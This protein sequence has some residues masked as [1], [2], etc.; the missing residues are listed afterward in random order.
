MS[1]RATAWHRVNQGGNVYMR[2]KNKLAA[3]LLGQF[4]KKKS[5]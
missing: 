5:L 1:P 3:E 4:E 2:K